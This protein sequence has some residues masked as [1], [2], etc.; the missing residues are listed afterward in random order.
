MKALTLTV[1]DELLEEL[2]QLACLVSQEPDL[3]V[4]IGPPGSGWSFSWALRQISMDEQRLRSE[5]NEYN[6]G[7]LLHEAGHAAITRLRPMLK[8]PYL[9]QPI[10]RGLIGAIEDA[11]LE[12][13]LQVQ[14]PGSGPWIRE[15]ND[16]LLQR[17]N[18]IDR[19]RVPPR[20][21]RGVD[22]IAALLA[23]WWFGA[24]EVAPDAGIQALV[25][26]A[27]PHL[28]AICREIP[29][30]GL[31][32]EAAY[33]RYRNHPW[34]SLFDETPD[35]VTR[36]AWEWE[37]RWCQ[38]RMWEH[39]TSGILPIFKEL[40]PPG[41]SSWV[42]KPAR[43]ILERWMNDAHLGPDP[44]SVPHRTKSVRH[45]G[46]GARGSGAGHRIHAGLHAEVPKDWPRNRNHYEKCLRA[47]AGAIEQLG[48]QVLG[49]LQ[50]REVRKFGGPHRS[51]NRLDLRA[52]FQATADPNRRECVWRR[53][54]HPLRPD[55]SITLLLDVSG[56]MD[57]E[58]I[59]AAV[60]ASVLLVEVCARVGIPVS[61]FAFSE[62][63]FRVWSHDEPLCDEGRGRIGGLAEQPSGGTR[64][65]AALGIVHQA[66]LN[67]AARDSYV[68]VL[69]DG[70]SNTGESP[71]TT[72]DV[73]ERDEIHVLG[74]GLGSRSNALR[75][76]IPKSRTQLTPSEVA[77]AFIDVL[78]RACTV[79]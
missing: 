52:A 78:L 35:P 17:P 66:V 44:R 30:G 64:M 1:R 45:G 26:R 6:R 5:S 79:P 70:M 15:Y 72:V 13:W 31:S 68:V 50:S 67:R 18:H 69:S 46:T 74:L 59:L 27:W 9:R 47:Q 54:A 60:S 34:V 3:R 40:W 25:D 2:R 48:Q 16:V 77:P 58:P 21:K 7:L 76:H 14:F 49:L 53:P 19:S 20:Q 61:V 22:F 73:M 12:T 36:E 37:T 63:C 4:V 62:S 39:L 41:G 38:L 10:L 8:E 57:G 43:L 56:S 32:R 28:E 55:A 33:E 65:A 51:G 29:R 42:G 75:E 24:G 23:R 11:R 71:R